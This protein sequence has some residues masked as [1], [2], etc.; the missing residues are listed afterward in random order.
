L[1]F[2]FT[3]EEVDL[4][5]TQDLLIIKISNKRGQSVHFQSEK[6]SIEYKRHCDQPQPDAENRIPGDVKIIHYK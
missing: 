1:I 2:I 6:A 3:D 5:S 4:I